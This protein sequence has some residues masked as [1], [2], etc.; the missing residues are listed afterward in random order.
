MPKSSNKL[1]IDQFGRLIHELRGERVMLNS[2]LA[3]IYSVDT[4]ALN[5]AVKRNRDRF[6]KT[7]CFNSREMNLNF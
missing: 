1:T 7:S 3:S 2:D 4:K 6:P 5:R